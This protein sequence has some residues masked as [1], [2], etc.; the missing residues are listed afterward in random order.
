MFM[1]L[2]IP[3]LAL[4]L[5]MLV[6]VS[7]SHAGGDLD[8]SQFTYNNEENGQGG[9]TG[10]SMTTEDDTNSNLASVSEGLGG[11]GLRLFLLVAAVLVVISLLVWAMKKN[12]APTP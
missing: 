10:T 12:S 5:L 7:L 1:K 6:G 2:Y 9:A 4:S 11:R 3:I 8:V